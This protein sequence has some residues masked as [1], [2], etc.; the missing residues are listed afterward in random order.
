MTTPMRILL[1]ETLIVTGN[2][3]ADLDLGL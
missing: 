3:H 1:E 2:V